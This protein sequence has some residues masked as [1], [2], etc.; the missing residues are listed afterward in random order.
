MFVNRGGAGN[1]E[2]NSVGRAIQEGLVGDVAETV[3]LDLGIHDQVGG[4]VHTQGWLCF[5]E[6]RCGDLILGR[7][8]CV[9]GSLVTEHQARKDDT[10]ARNE[11]NIPIF[12]FHFS[13]LLI[14]CRPDGCYKLRRGPWEFVCT[15]RKL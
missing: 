13:S 7:H 9:G 8:Q 5:V 2:R 4:Q 12:L 10:E 15:E 14:F 6:I 11:R 1:Y 3:R